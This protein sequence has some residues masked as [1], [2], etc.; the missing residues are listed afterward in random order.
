MVSQLVAQPVQFRIEFSNVTVTSVS[1]TKDHGYI[2]AGFSD[3]YGIG[4]KDIVMV[5]TDSIG[6]IL[7][8]KTFGC[9]TNSLGDDVAANAIENS[10]SDG[11]FYLAGQLWNQSNGSYEV[12]VLKTDTEGN[13]L[14]SKTLYNG[15]YDKGVSVMNASGGGCYVAGWVGNSSK[16]LLAKVN[17]SGTVA[18]QETVS[19][20]SGTWVLQPGRQTSDGGII[21]GGYDNELGLYE[22]WVVKTNSSGSIQWQGGYAISGTYNFCYDVCQTND[23]GYLLGGGGNTGINLARVDSNGTLIWSKT[24]SATY[25]YPRA[26][27]VNQ[28]ID[29]GFIVLSNDIGNDQYLMKTDSIGNVEWTSQYSGGYFINTVEQ[30]SDKGFILAMGD[31]VIKTD[32]NGNS[33]CEDSFVTFI[34][35]TL[36]LVTRTPTATSTSQSSSVAAADSSTDP[37]I[38]ATVLCLATSVNKSIA[39][40]DKVMIY[41]NPVTATC[42]IVSKEFFDVNHITI[43]DLTGRKI[44]CRLIFSENANHPLQVDCSELNQGIYFLSIRTN[45]GVLSLKF[46][47]M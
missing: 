9:K 47:K 15:G 4:S 22:M 45:G 30:T 37:A 35:D 2:I 8:Q 16:G 31:A 19:K 3:S 1:Q 6:S 27:S 40:E 11:G 12:Y 23:H 13:K 14:W 28:C 10:E 46:L 36:T 21:V 39:I 26:Y 7:W 43:S 38:T 32:E 42:S 25:I 17:A 29:K 33:G 5:K 24:Y 41:P 34:E 18:W 44:N 20:S